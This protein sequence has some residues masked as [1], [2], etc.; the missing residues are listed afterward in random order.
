MEPLMMFEEVK[1]DETTLEPLAMVEGED[2]TTLAQMEMDG[3]MAK[4]VCTK[5]EPLMI[6]ETLEMDETPEKWL[7][8]QKRW[9]TPQWRRERDS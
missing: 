4:V 2:E 8:S 9:L 6:V 7:G 3:P 1:V 5:M